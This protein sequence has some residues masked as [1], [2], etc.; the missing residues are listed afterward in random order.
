[1]HMF[2]HPHKLTLCMTTTM[3]V[4][5]LHSKA[6]PQH[7]CCPYI[8]SSLLNTLTNSCAAQGQ[9]SKA[10]SFDAALLCPSMLPPM[11]P[12]T[13]SCMHPLHACVAAPWM[14]YTK[15]HSCSTSS[16]AIHS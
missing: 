8:T 9:L 12:F 4:L 3:H 16:D 14:R 11:P 10:D 1:M 13:Q 7:S 5:R 15:A 2:C 6:R